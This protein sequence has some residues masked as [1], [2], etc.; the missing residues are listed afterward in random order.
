M[1][2]LIDRTG[3]KYNRLIVIGRLPNNKHRAA[4]WLCR[5]DCGAEVG[6][7]A[8]KLVTGN[9]KSCGCLRSEV[10]AK[11]NKKQ[12]TTHG[13]RYTPL[14]QVWIDMRR[15]CYS[16]SNKA[17]RLYGA[18]GIAVC[19]AWKKDFQAFYDWAIG[20]GY[21]EGLTIDRKKSHKNYCPLNCQW[22]TK[23]ENSRKADHGK[24]ESGERG[25]TWHSRSLRWRVALQHNRRRYYLGSFT[26]LKEAVR[27]IRRKKKELGIKY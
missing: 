18:K 25:V 26:D 1:G 5:C 2:N 21:R 17:Y 7:D 3:K 20:S 12:M 27:V 14:Y 23:G 8:R 9:T 24:S 13:M 16:K 10:T 22:I 11:R 6:V 4:V 19:A 15:R